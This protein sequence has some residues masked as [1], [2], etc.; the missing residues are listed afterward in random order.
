MESHC[1]GKHSQVASRWNKINTMLDNTP[2]SH[3]AL[4]YPDLCGEKIDRKSCSSHQRVTLIFCVCFRLRWNGEYNTCLDNNR[5]RNMCLFNHWK[6]PNGIQFQLHRVLWGMKLILISK[7]SFAFGSSDTTC[8]PT[9][10]VYFVHLKKNSMKMIICR[11]LHILYFR[12]AG[13]YTYQASVCHI[14]NSRHTV[15]CLPHP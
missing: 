9:E 12:M 13:K 2:I 8:W 5:S 6:L 7:H 14:S 11:D 4:I 10:H 15:Y 3:A 1:T